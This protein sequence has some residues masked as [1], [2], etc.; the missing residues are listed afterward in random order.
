MLTTTLNKLGK[1]HLFDK[2]DPQNIYLPIIQEILMTDRNDLK[3]YL[4]TT[5]NQ[6]YMRRLIS[7]NMNDAFVVLGGGDP[8]FQ[9][10]LNDVCNITA[11]DINEMQKLVFSLKKAAIKS[12][13]LSAYEKFLIDCEGIHFLSNDI[14]KYVVDGFSKEESVERDIWET[15][16]S[17]LNGK[18]LLPGEGLKNCLFKGGVEGCSI[19]YARNCLQFIRKNR[20][21]NKVRENLEKANITIKT[22]D[23]AEIILDEGS[24]SQY[25]YI[26]LTNILLFVYQSLGETSFKEYMDKLMKIYDSKLRKDGVMVFDY[27]FGIDIEDLKGDITTSD[28]F[29]SVY[30]PTTKKLQQTFDVETFKVDATPQ[31]STLTGK[32]DTII[33]KRKM[34]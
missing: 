27:L 34:K 22:G 26:D 9:L 11:V 14:F 13:N 3:P 32:N 8:I 4:N 7:E 16:F 2:N 24:D 23:F 28:I 29:K 19:E 18:Q 20:L 10:L 33:Y 21:Y 17:I 31:A 6:E 25:D 12:L 5:Q 15:L 30:Y 1:N